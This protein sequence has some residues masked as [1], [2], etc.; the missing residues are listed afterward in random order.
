MQLFLGNITSTNKVRVIRGR[1]PEF[2]TAR[3]RL[4]DGLSNILMGNIE[5]KSIE[6]VFVP[7][8]SSSPMVLDKEDLIVDFHERYIFNAAL[9]FRQAA[10]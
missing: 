7:F 2:C 6:P 1:L 5:K 8:P 4:I 3:F 10:F 9:A